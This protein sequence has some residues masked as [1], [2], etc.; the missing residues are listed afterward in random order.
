MGENKEIPGKKR[1][2][3]GDSDS[4]IKSGSDTYRKSDPD[5]NIKNMDSKHLNGPEFDALNVEEESSYITPKF[6]KEDS[7][8]EKNLR[9]GY[10]SDFIGQEKI[11][12]NLSIFISSAKKRNEPLDHVILSGPPGLGKTCIAE[13]IANELGVNFKITSGPAI[14]RAGDLA[15]ILTN[16]EKF[17]VLFID[18]MHRLNRAIEEVLYPVME[19]FKLDI[20]IGK[21]PSARSIRIDIAP[22]TIIGATT[23]IGL[24]AAPL[25]DRFGVNLRLDF[26]DLEN[27]KNIISRSATI[28]DMKISEDGA[29]A[30]ARRSRGTPRIANR[31]L[32]RVRDYAMMYDEDGEI[33]AKI[34]D[35][36][37][38]KLDI[39]VLGLD[40]IDK[41]ILNTIVTKFD[42][43]PVGVGTIAV[44]IGEEVDTVEDVYEPYLIQLGFIKRTSK[45]RMATDL[46]FRHL[47]IENKAKKENKDNEKRLF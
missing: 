11:I 14:E 47:G 1:S 20:I 45:G 8:L 44:S 33:T 39:D 3:N 2:R 23:R 6:K 46:A 26:Y 35:G 38:T 41:K 42:G 12:D 28:L 36:A 4:Y 19:D 13:I 9:P 5:S 31:L 15:A 18:E 27:I 16:L 21:G 25:R 29:E 43:G 37:L 17:D 30:I 40:I 32:K 22:F 34:A 10:F 24:I 7:D